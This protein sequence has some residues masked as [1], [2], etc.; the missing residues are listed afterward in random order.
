MF[1]DL[2]ASKVLVTASA[3][4]QLPDLPGNLVLVKAEAGQ[5]LLFGS[6]LSDPDVAWL[7]DEGDDT[8][9]LPLDNASRLWARAVS[10]SATVRAVVLG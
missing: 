9:L 10:G 6:N 2:A 4:V 3:T 5:V 1:T 7:L 8:G